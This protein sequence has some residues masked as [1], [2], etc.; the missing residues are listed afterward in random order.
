[1]VKIDNDILI[2]I[3]SAYLCSWLSMQN[4][5]PDLR[6][7]GILSQWIC[8]WHEPANRWRFLKRRRK[9]RRGRRREEKL[10]C[11]VWHLSWKHAY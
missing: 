4:I 7:R 3:L 1:M 2:W 8:L 11:T 5:L 9:G 10:F 6:R